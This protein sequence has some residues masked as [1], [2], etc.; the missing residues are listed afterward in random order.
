MMNPPVFP[1]PEDDDESPDIFSVFMLVTTCFSLIV[2]LF[3]I[4]DF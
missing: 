1:P 2:L 4:F 3:V